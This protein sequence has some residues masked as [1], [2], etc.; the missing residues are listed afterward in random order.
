MYQ[1]TSNHKSISIKLTFKINRKTDQ[2]DW[3]EIFDDKKEN[4]GECNLKL[5]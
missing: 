4:S 1:I 5:I 2:T 3:R